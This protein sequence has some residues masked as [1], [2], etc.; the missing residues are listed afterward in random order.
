MTAPAPGPDPAETAEIAGRLR[1]AIQHLLPVLRA[2]R[3]A[4]GDLTPSRQAAL[5]ALAAHGPLRISELAARMGIALSTTSRMVDLLDS[6][7]WIER[8]PD[9]QDQ[10]A[11]LVTLSRTGRAVLEARRRETA[12]R[13]AEQITLL[14]AE[15]QRALYAAL[16]ALE[17]LSDR[18][19]TYPG[20]LPRGI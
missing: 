19:T 16:P 10:R 12:A 20:E 8:H 7:G 5:A 18:A 9:P 14:T 2:R 15:E 6:T 1:L 4:P 11:S 17:A 13:L 3:S